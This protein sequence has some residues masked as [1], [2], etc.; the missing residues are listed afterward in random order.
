MKISKIFSEMPNFISMGFDVFSTPG[1]FLRNFS[2]LKR[3][4]LSQVENFPMKKRAKKIFAIS[5]N[6]FFCA[7]FKFI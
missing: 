4:P 5:Q 2:I 3:L 7:V 6:S 1:R